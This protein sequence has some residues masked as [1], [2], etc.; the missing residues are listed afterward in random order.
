M[1]FRGGIKN[2]VKNDEFCKSIVLVIF[3]LFVGASIVQGTVPIS[4]DGCGEDTYPLFAAHASQN[5]VVSMKPYFS[6][7]IDTR[8][9]TEPPIYIG[10]IGETDRLSFKEFAGTRGCYGGTFAM[11][12]N[13]INYLH[14][15][16]GDDGD[17]LL[18]LLYEYFGICSPGYIFISVSNNDGVSWNE[19]CWIDIPD[20]SY[21]SVDYWGHCTQFYGTFLPPS[22]FQNGAVFCLIDIPHPLFPSTWLI[23]YWCME[24]YGWYGMKM[25]EIASDD[26]QQPWNWGFLSAILSRFYC[27]DYLYDVPMIFGEDYYYGGIASYFPTFDNCMTT[28]ADI[29]H[30]NG[31]TYAVYD[32]YDSLANQYQLFIRQDYFYNWYA[33]TDA[34]TIC[35]AD[36]STHLTNPVVAA[37]NNHIVVLAA[38][39]NTIDPEDT[40]IICFYTDD[41]DVDNLN[42]MSIVADT[43]DAENFPEISHL[44]DD[45]F[46]C[47][48]VKNN[49][50]YACITNDGGSTWSSPVQVNNLDELVVEEYRTDDI[51]DDGHK[52]VYEYMLT[53]DDNI[54]LGIENPDL[55]DS[56][57]D[58]VPD[59]VDNCPMNPNPMQDDS[60]DDS[61]GDVCDNCQNV[62]NPTQVDT[63]E[64]GIGDP[65]DNCQ[66]V[67]NPSQIDTDNDTIGDLCD[68]CPLI[69]NPLQDDIDSDGIGDVCDLCPEDPLNDIDGDGF[70]ANEDNC[71][72]AYNPEQDD[73]DLDGVGDTCDNCVS[74]PNPDQ[75]D[76]DSDGIGDLCDNCTDTDGDGYG[77][78]NYPTNTCPD[79][80][81]PYVYNPGQEDTNG[82][83]IGDAC[84]SCGDANGDGTVDI[85]DTVYLINYLFRN[86]PAPWLLCLGDSNGDLQI[87]IADIVY[88]INYLFTNGPAPLSQCCE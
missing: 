56:D 6:D 4:N 66:N 59:S 76:R 42:T 48:F 9:V 86:G 2:M 68:N 88:L 20:A 72:H 85:A 54:Y 83:G 63:D 62:P 19:C 15:A 79:D 46:T 64:D 74:V 32:R 60:D 22:W 52:I 5:P 30:I 35:F 49:S 41:G 26:G 77:N 11:G 39:N 7:Q 28:S 58:G 80:N 55:T 27:G 44:E 78:P 12:L 36:P 45:R 61:I 53:G 34:V 40:D 69:P 24:A 16:L 14:P 10:D 18:V 67:P 82:D 75:F 70:C 84:S 21:P 1:Y 87:N 65:C 37:N 29:D 71:P 33:G 43:E 8:D 57:G 51:G 31:K 23:I 3:A 73:E 13:S 17:G 38:A 81:C 25:V 47:T 50:L